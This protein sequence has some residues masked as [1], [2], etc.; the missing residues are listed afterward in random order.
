MPKKALPVLLVVHPSVRVQVG[1]NVIPPGQADR[2]HGETPAEITR[3]VREIYGV[4][5][6]ETDAEQS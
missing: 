5:P 4:D 6:P 1:C 3:L 2:S